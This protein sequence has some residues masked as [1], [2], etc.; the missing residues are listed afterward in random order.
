MLV[1]A[2]TVKCIRLS[3]AQLNSEYWIGELHCKIPHLQNSFKE[4]HKTTF[5]D[6][7]DLGITV[8]S[9]EML[10]KVWLLI[11]F[12]WFFNEHCHTSFPVFMAKNGSVQAQVSVGCAGEL[13]S[14]AVGDG[15]L[16]WQPTQSPLLLQQTPSSLNETIHNEYKLTPVCQWQ[17]NL[18]D[19][20]NT[21]KETELGHTGTK[22]GGWWGST[23]RLHLP[24]ISRSLSPTSSHICFHPCFLSAAWLSLLRVSLLSQSSALLWI[25]PVTVPTL[26]PTLQ[27]F[28]V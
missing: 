10:V 4:I 9:G 12:N 14:E 7:Y 19:V 22:T 26:S 8:A 16:W 25:W 27:N 23:V 20:L 5:L 3:S 21:R 15:K 1:F 11:F 18:I 28:S 6:R 2:N 17:S 13:L 24:F